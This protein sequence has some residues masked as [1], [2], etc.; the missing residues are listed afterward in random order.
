MDPDSNF[1]SESHHILEDG[2]KLIYIAH[3][4]FRLNNYLGISNFRFALFE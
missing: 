1:K 2:K 3:H 4:D